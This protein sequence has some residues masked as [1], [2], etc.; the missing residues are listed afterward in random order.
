MTAEV[1]TPTGPGGASRDELYRRV[2]EIAAALE[3]LEPHSPVP[4]LLKRCVRLGG[5]AFP[6]LMRELV[7]EVNTLDEFDRLLGKA[8]A[9]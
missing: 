2:G 7:R 6:E 8:D 5:M 4:L 9:K 1:A 3:R